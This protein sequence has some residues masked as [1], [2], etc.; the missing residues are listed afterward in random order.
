[1]SYLQS[2]V[3]VVKNPPANAGDSGSVLESGRSPEGKDNPLQYSCLRKP[4][5]RGDWWVIVFGV[6]KQ[7]DMTWRLNDNMLLLNLNAQGF[8]HSSVGKESA[9][10]AGDPGSIPGSGRPPG[11]GIGYPLQYSWASFVTQLVQNPPAMWEIW[12]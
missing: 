12:V 9:C 2:C 6:A 1:M 7:S 11:E 10:S 8:P 3:S 5:D 4:M